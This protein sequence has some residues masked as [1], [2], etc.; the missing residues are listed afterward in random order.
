M[1]GLPA[2]NAKRNLRVL[3][4]DDDEQGRPLSDYLSIVVRR[5]LH[6]LLPLLLT[7]YAA[8]IVAIKLPRAYRSSATILIE[9]QQIPREMVHT[10]VT[11][12]ADQRIQ[13][14]KQRVLTTK[15]ILGIIEKYTLYPALRHKISDTELSKRFQD[16]A[17]VTLVGADVFDPQQGRESKATIAFTIAFSDAE[18]TK[19]QA[20]A[21][22]LVSLFLSENMRSRTQRARRTTEFMSEEAEKLK[23]ELQEL[24]NSIAEYKQQFAS[25]LPTL[26]STNLAMI[27]RATSELQQAESQAATVRDRV[28]FL[29]AQIAQAR[30][31]VPES[32]G[33]AQRVL[34]PGEQL[35]VWKAEYLQLSSRYK[36][37]HPDVQRLRAQIRA[38]EPSFNAGNSERTSE[39]ARARQSLA[40][41]RRKYSASHPEV[42]AQRSKVAELERQATLAPS[43]S[44]GPNSGG[45]GKSS[46]L[47]TLTLTAQIKSSEWELQTLT[48]R[49]ERLRARI[50]ELQQNVAQTPQ[51][52]RGYQDMLREHKN[53]LQKYSE[54]KAKASEAKLAQ[55][56]EEEQRGESFTL[57]EPPVV[58]TKPESSKRTKV[59]ALGGVMGTAFGVG[60]A[61][62]AELLDGTLRGATALRQVA[63]QAPLLVIPYLGNQSDLSRQRRKRKAF[64]LTA[65]ILLLTA[66]IVFHFAAMPLPELVGRLLSAGA[67]G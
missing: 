11:D 16:S 9:D 19:A 17:E 61:A 58:P 8:T 3:E 13:L 53:S 49:Q 5:K 22:E 41:L 48:Q 54:L 32:R 15:S 37:A 46:D 6:I 35:R 44:T 55:T 27:E 26:L 63:G 50:S 52:E 40:A 67:P 57:I 4:P 1:T 62:A 38:F 51:V 28:E 12:Y 65:L 25:S 23:R 29:K 20:V 56:L 64:W 39:L 42:L 66:I 7:V 10:T 33:D 2:Y 24:E 30:A 59:I 47:A 36:S 60:T 31:T 43:V 21:N 34:S 14:I 45:T 18:P